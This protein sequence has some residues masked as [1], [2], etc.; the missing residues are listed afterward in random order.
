MNTFRVA[1]AA[2]RARPTAMRL[3]IQPLQRRTYAEAAS[4]KVCLDNILVPKLSLTSS[5]DQAE[6]V[7]PP[8]GTDIDIYLELTYRHESI[9]IRSAML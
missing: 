3:P 4:D 9:T 5:S 1:R 8:P 6:L 2:L 7:S